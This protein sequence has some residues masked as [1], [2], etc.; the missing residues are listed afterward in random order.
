MSILDKLA[1]SQNIRND[2]PNKELAKELA[3]EKNKE[4]IR[5][6]AINLY[7]KDKKIQ[8]NCLKVLYE[9]GYINPILIEDYVKDFLELL[10]NKNNRLVWGGMIA[11]ST[12]ADRKPDEIF[13]NLDN[14]I[15]IIEKGSVITFD[16]GMIVLSKVA[17]KDKKYNQKI[18]PILIDY[19]K[20]CRPSSVAQYSE[21]ISIAL[22]E[23]NKEEFINVLYTRP[24]DL[25]TPQLKR[26][27][28]LLKK[29]GSF[30][31]S[32]ENSFFC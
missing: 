23:D 29:I 3:E 8:S 1:C 32:V 15:K 5:E 13:L 4:G 25:T 10:N 7:N 14:I 6:I 24:I 20:N 16:A 22:N 12:I 19:L 17:S 26:V 27:K 28:K 31:L 21:S 11:L 30:G 2:I 9:I 18:F